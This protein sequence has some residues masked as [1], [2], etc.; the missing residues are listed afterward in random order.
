MYRPGSRAFG[1]FLNPRE[2][3]RYAPASDSIS[4]V[5]SFLRRAGLSTSWQQGDSWLMVRGPATAVDR[6]FYVDVHEYTSAGGI[7]YYASARDPGVPAG[8]RA[9]VSAAG[10]IDSFR[11]RTH[12]VPHSI[13]SGGLTP[14]GLL[15]A[16]DL[17]PLRDMGLD[18]TG[19][20]VAFV[21]IDGFNQ[22]DFDQFTSVF[23]HLSSMN[24]IIKYGQPSSDV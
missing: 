6:T 16:Y 17:K 5:R 20:T 1:R 19:Q 12:L 24:P 9:D 10:R 8:L 15:A 22:Q 23:S 14:D 2:L 3:A 18:G 7:H 21:E 13:P 4:R 11:E